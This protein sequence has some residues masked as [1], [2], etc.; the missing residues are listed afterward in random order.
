MVVH[1][2]LICSPGVSIMF[3]TSSLSVGE[4]GGF[5]DLTVRRIGD[6][7]LPV[8]VQL[9]LLDQGTASELL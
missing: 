9:S 2:R 1:V 4:D 3:D 5:V 8:T 6:S 7:Q